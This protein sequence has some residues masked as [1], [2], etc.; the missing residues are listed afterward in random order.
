MLPTAGGFLL[1]VLADSVDAPAWVAALSPFDH[2][3]L[4]PGS[5]P[6]VPAALVMLALAA[7]I[8]AIG[9]LGYHRRDIRGD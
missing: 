2:L 6:D 3:A 1:T 8:G 5:P 7:G 9:V 4:V